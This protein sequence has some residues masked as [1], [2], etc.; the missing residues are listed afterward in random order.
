MSLKQ[1]FLNAL[2]GAAEAARQGGKS[3]VAMEAMRK[4]LESKTDEEVGALTKSPRSVGSYVKLF[5]KGAEFVTEVSDFL[6]KARGL[7]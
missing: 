7:G 4:D 2:E 3:D 6:K 5:V 1:E